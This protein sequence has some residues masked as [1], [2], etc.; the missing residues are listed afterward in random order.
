[1]KAATTMLTQTRRKL[2]PF[3]SD[4]I[5]HPFRCH[6]HQH[7]DSDE[8]REIAAVAIPRQA[9][10]QYISEGYGSWGRPPDLMVEDHTPSA[11]PDD[12][13]LSFLPF[14]GCS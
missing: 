10:G 3:S 14:A 2:L 12:E 7:R 8:Q 6:E 11:Y 13:E 4:L 5:A 1:M 9:M